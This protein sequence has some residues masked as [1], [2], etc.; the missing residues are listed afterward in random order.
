ML[1]ESSKMNF[2]SREKKYLVGKTSLQEPGVDHVNAIL[3][4]ISI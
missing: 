3:K 4:A 2:I 1:Q